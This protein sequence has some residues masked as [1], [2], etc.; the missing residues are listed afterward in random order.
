LHWLVRCGAERP[1]DVGDDGCSAPFHS[2]PTECLPS[3]DPV[4][5]EPGDPQMLNRYSYVRNNPLRYTDPSGLCFWEGMEC[6]P[7][8]AFVLTTCAG[9]SAEACADALALL[10]RYDL[11]IQYWGSIENF[12]E[13]AR[14]G[15]KLPYFQEVGYPGNDPVAAMSA[16]G[17]PNSLL[18]Q[19]FT[20]AYYGF[21]SGR[22]F[23]TGIGEAKTLDE[24]LRE[25]AEKAK[26]T[27]AGVK[28]ALTGSC[29]A[30]VAQ[31]ALGLSQWAAGNAAI[32]AAVPLGAAAPETVGASV[33]LASVAGIA[34]GTL[35]VSGIGNIVG[36]LAHMSGGCS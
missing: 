3:P 17:D 14:A 19:L 5:A 24:L 30:G 2:T 27:L 25:A 29:A 20:L 28:G 23:T 16:N 31:A 9:S 1:T 13:W 33:T 32:E 26:E 8:I 34:G 36:G 11:A 7:E 12:M 10:G 35:I 18:G 21:W 4:I 6:S 22:A 15:A